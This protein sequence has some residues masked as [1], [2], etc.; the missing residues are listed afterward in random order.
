MVLQCGLREFGDCSFTRHGTRHTAR[1]VALEI[2]TL[3]CNTLDAED[4]R[5]PALRFVCITFCLSLS[6]IR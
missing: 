1:I 5:A 6:H 3:C 2:R 4:T